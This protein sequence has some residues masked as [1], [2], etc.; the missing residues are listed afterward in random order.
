MV[1]EG[2]FRESWGP[3]EAGEVDGVQFDVEKDQKAADKR[4]EII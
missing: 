3:W 4:G 2:K 1:N